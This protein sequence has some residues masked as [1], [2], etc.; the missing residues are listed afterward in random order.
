MCTARE[1]ETSSDI[2]MVLMRHQRLAKERTCTSRPCESCIAGHRERVAQF[3]SRGVA[4]DFALPAFP[5]KS[6]NR[7]KVI[8]VSPDM[9]EQLSL[10][11]LR[12]I[13]DQ[14]QEIHA[15]G[16]RITIVPTA[17]CSVISYTSLIQTL[18]PVRPS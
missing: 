12:K 18:H 16:V 15:P 14:I 4:V 1:H 6:P 10:N 2:L 9:A 17:M 5:G 7:S 3:V 11:F 8:G 13:C